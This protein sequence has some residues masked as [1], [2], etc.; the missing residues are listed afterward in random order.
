M[1]KPVNPPVVLSSTFTFECAAAEARAARDKT[2]HIYTR[3]SN[4]TNDAVEARIADLEGADRALLAG[5][6]MG[7]ISVALIHAAQQ[8]GTILVQEPVYGGT[9]ELCEHLLKGFGV[10][11]ARATV[12]ALVAA[13]TDL[14]PTSIYMELPANPTN[15]I[16]DLPAVRAAAPDAC[17]LVDATFAT[18]VNCRPLEHGADVVLHSASKYLGGHH[19][20]LAGVIAGSGRRMDALWHVRKL[21]GPTLDPQAAYRLWRGLE[22]L[23]V[24][25]ARINATAALLAS[26]LAEHP[27]VSA[28]HYP[29]LDAHPDHALAPTLLSGFGGVVS[30]D[31][32]AERAGAVADALQ[33]F[34]NG[35]SLGGVRSLVSWPAGVSH[36][37]VSPEER[38][39][40][41]ISD[42]LLRLSIGL[43]DPEI[44]WQDL[45]EALA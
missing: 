9:H 21:L 19:D 18:P 45:A 31:V 29:T 39:R 13:A 11:I 26:R 10:T 33:H 41:G 38:A 42:G 35:P 12:D 15:R 40:A 6:G 36:I 28:V 20:L 16:A 30:I 5:S 34:A 17:I 25:M 24:R 37:N 23:E 22:T 1:S 3:W 4:P 7:A 44:L 14:R 27:T 2:P 32:P 43:E 8:G